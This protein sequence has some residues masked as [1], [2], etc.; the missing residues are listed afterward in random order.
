MTYNLTSI[1]SN[2]TSY[3]E[4]TQNINDVLMFGWLGVLMLFG[5]CGV[6]LIG[7]YFITQDIRKSM[8]GTLFI[9]FTSAL[10]L[11]ALDLVPDFAV[12]VTLI[13]LALAIAFTFK[14]Q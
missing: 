2:A 9:G 10:S 6:F 14:S 12:W 11:R 13:G 3:L 4:F 1:S 8:I 7:F 5:I